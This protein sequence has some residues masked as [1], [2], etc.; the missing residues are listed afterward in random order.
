[1]IVKNIID[2]DYINFKTPS[3]FISTARCN[4]KCCIEA[5]IPIETCQ[6]NSIASMPD[7]L[8]SADEI[9]R[10][11]LSNPLSH[12]V[13]FGGLEP[14]LQFEDVLMV[15]ERFR[16]CGVDDP[17]VIYT[18]YTEVE[19]TDKISFLPQFA[20]IIVKFGR[21]VPNDQPHFD[22]VLGVTLVSQNQYAKPIKL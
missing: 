6:N 11:Y 21:Y 4:W 13:V 16:A 20:P 12:S 10:R 18:G 19:V 22:E 8:I 5:H 1:M 9:L 14:M 17:F 7:I 3:M 15:I 2:T